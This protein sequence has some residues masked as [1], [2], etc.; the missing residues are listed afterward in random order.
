MEAFEKIPK[1]SQESQSMCDM[2]VLCEGSSPDSDVW[3]YEVKSKT[4]IK[5]QGIS[6]VRDMEC[7]PRTLL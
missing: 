6:D 3:N 4:A 7:L 5:T 2:V 1:A